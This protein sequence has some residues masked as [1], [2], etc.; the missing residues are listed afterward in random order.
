M[1]QIKEIYFHQM[2]DVLL[3]NM[4]WKDF[5]ASPIVFDSAIKVSWVKATTQELLSAFTGVK[6]M[7]RILWMCIASLV[8]HRDKSA[9]FW[10]KS[11]CKG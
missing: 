5:A 6:G 10:V 2:P 8:Y 7:Q 9:E 1:G 4:F 3:L 11:Y